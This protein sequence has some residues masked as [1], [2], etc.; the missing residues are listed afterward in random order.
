MDT[1]HEG[2]A[3]L[4]LVSALILKL[5]NNGALIPTDKKTLISYAQSVAGSFPHPQGSAARTLLGEFGPLH[6]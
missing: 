3:A 6:N 1:N 2:L 4:C 5:E